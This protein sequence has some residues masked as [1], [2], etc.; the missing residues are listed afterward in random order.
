MASLSASLKKLSE[1][2][3][4]FHIFLDKKV[5]GASPQ[6]ITFGLFGIINYPVFYFTWTNVAPQQYE[7]LALRLIAAFLCIPLILK[8]YWPHRLRRYLAIY[9]YLTLVYCLPFFGTFMLL[10]NHGSPM[11]VTNAML[12]LLLLTLLVD[13]IS[14]TIIL[15][16]G[17]AA[18]IITYFSVNSN[19]I[20]L[21][22]YWG[23]LLTYISA[24]II[25]AIFAHTRE[26]LEQAKFQAMAAI[27]GNIA[28][29]L[30]TPLRA[31]N[32]GV[33]GIKQYFPTLISSYQIASKVDPNLQKIRLDRF[34]ALLTSLDEIQTCI[35]NSNTFIN[36]LL[37][38]INPNIRSKELTVCSVNECIDEAMRN[39]PFNSP[40]QEKL[41]TWE[42]DNDFKFIGSKLLI[43]HVL[44][45]LFKNALFFIED[46]GKGEISIWTEIGTKNNKL[47]F[48]D[49]SKGIS[50]NLLPQLFN[51]FFTQRLNGT[52]LGLSFCK[53]VMM[54]IG[55]DITCR[56]KEGEYTEFI[57]TFPKIKDSNN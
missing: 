53:M 39:Y 18:A 35:D 1:L 14:F 48:K 24:V 4:R 50:E 30:R 13:W 3:K 49:T 15:L 9:W 33:S 27:G 20:I 41:I 38:K 57:M 31:I 56:S 37:V 45:N 47:F 44:F 16:I 54:G 51:R 34:E 43:M 25:A 55:G 28:H 46:A 19:P 6:L 40:N 23:T 22:D 2:F 17:I 21:N 42:P 12:V 11:W 36:M 26:R 29:E 52:G 5:E 32:S 7:S 10:Q 8:N